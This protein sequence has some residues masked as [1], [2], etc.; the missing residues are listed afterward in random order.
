MSLDD[1]IG[2]VKQQK[3][4]RDAFLAGKLT[5]SQPRHGF[6]A[7]LDS[8]LLGAAVSA[9]RSSLLDL[10]AG[11]GTAALVALALNP[12]LVATLAENDDG[13]ADLAADNIAQNGL[14][15]RASLTRIDLTAPGPQRVA[16]GLLPDHFATVIANPPFFESGTGTAPSAARQAARHMP[17]EAL[18]RWVRTA[19]A[20]AAPGGEVIFI[21][22]A[23]GLPALLASLA[24][25][26]GALSVLPLIPR[27]GEAASRVLIRGIKGS[28]APLQL[29]ASRA[30][31]GADGRDFM[32]AF[33]AIFRGQAR[34]DW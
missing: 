25:R 24:A 15:A 31:H 30:L 18:D 29:L 8:V 23:Q 13:V 1:T 9:D 26:F 34:L 19:A 6:R 16:A 17:A 2:L 21:Y 20:T 7:G 28:R 22:P 12:H 33:D 10:G 3:H 5:L 27:D 14:A 32:P 11:V 4:T